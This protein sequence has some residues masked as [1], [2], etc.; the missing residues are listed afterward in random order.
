MNM[1]GELLESAAKFGM[2]LMVN[3]KKPYE[4]TTSIHLL[5]SQL[6]NSDPVFSQHG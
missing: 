4:D 6:R 2:I 3:E 5:A 1:A